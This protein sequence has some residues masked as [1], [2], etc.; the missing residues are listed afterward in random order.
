MTFSEFD[1]GIR[2]YF[3]EIGKTDLLTPAQEIEL[4]ERIQR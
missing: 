4:A 1:G 2:S 3:Q